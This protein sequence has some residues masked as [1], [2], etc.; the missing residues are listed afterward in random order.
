MNFV[1]STYFTAIMHHT[2]AHITARF[3]ETSITTT[4][5]IIA[6]I[7]LFAKYRPTIMGFANRLIKIAG[8]QKSK[9]LNKLVTYCE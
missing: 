3:R 2:I 9:V 4:T 1:W 5:I 6:I 8:Y 7:I